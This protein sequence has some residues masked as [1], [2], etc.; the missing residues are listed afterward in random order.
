MF[1]EVHIVFSGDKTPRPSISEE[2]RLECKIYTPIATPDLA[3]FVLDISMGKQ[4]QET[5][6][7]RVACSGANSCLLI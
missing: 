6:Q 2:M 3:H 7:N 1:A 4:H 5:R